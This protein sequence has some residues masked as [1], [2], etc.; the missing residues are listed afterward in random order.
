MS[1][2][3]AVFQLH[4]GVRVEFSKVGFEQGNRS[5]GKFKAK[6]LLHCPGDGDRRYSELDQL[7]D[8]VC[9][10][11]EPK[12]ASG[13][14]VSARWAHKPL[15]LGAIPVFPYVSCNVSLDPAL[16]ESNVVSEHEGRSSPPKIDASTIRAG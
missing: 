3:Y 1:P 4:V 15:A 12:L 8:G 16:K 9:T 14:D 5:A 13:E 6:Q 11:I 2:G 7:I 10:K